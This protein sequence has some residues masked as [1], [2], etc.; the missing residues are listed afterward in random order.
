MRIRKGMTP[1][2]KAF[3]EFYIE[4]GDS[5][6]AATKAGYSAKTADV[7][8][9]TLKRKLEKEIREAVGKAFGHRSVEAAKI[10][11]DLAKNST[12]E[13]TRYNAA[14]DVLDRAGY[15]PKDKVEI[16]DDEPVDADDL[17]R[18]V[19]ASLAN[20]PQFLM[21]ILRSDRQAYLAVAGA[22]EQLKREFEQPTPAIETQENKQ[23]RKTVH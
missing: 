18:Q 1:K 11:F 12:N 16:L 4:S 13:A 5:T 8:G 22:V 7:Q 3:L 19:A 2:E 6:D 20:N 14:A 17:M 23:E 10:V 21:D 9:C 15:K